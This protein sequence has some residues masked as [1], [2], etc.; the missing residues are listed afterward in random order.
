MFFSRGD[1]LVPHLQ[2]SDGAR[3]VRHLDTKAHLN[4]GDHGGSASTRIVTAVLYLN[5]EWRQEHGGQL[6]V[7]LPAV[8]P[9]TGTTPPGST[10]FHWDVAPKGGRL[11]VFRSDRVEHEV[12][13]SFG[14]PRYAVTM[15]MYGTPSTVSEVPRPLPEGTTNGTHT[16]TQ[17]A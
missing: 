3:Y 5:P 7:Y 17:F 8:S 14:V 10:G 2:A 11:L 9:V 1:N 13:P 12:L 4:V 6:R 16:H 15:W